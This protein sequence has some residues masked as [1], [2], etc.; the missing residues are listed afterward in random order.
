M[1][2]GLTNALAIF[3]DLMNRVFQYFL[4]LFVIVFKGNILVYSW[5]KVDHSNHHCIVFAYPE[6][7]AVV[8]QIF[9]IQILVEYCDFSGSYH[10]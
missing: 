9:E 8:C 7:L 6:R 5:S 4:Y 1:S 2:F 3:I 10:I